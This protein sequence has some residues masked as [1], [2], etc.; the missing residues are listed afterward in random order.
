MREVEK[1]GERK[2]KKDTEG[3]RRGEEMG[4]KRNEKQKEEGM[5]SGGQQNHVSGMVHGLE[6]WEKSTREDLEGVRLRRG[7][8]RV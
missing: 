4:R 5:E 8:I 2:K 6:V 1:G 3:E 7:S